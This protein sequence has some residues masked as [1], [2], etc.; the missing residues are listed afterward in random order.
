MTKQ[1]FKAQDELA[2]DTFVE[3]LEANRRTERGQVNDLEGVA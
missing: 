1:M 3:R 2:A